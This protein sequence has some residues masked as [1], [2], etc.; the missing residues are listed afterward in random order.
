MDKL[1]IREYSAKSFVIIGDSREFKD[2]I[3][4]LGGKWNTKLM[5]DDNLSSGWIFPNSLRENVDKWFLS[6]ELKSNFQ[7]NSIKVTEESSLREEL[8]QIKKK[9]DN[10]LSL[11]NSK[12]ISLENN[13]ESDDD[14]FKVKRTS[15]LPKRKS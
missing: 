14:D 13:D 11:L 9:L 2:Q 8:D 5:I 12:K 10:I 7:N 1:S 15:L 4:T 3:K 6:G